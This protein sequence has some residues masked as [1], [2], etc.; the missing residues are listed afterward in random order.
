MFKQDGAHL[1]QVFGAQIIVQ[2][3]AIHLRLAIVSKK[4]KKNIQL[5]GKKNYLSE[6]NEVI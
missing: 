1:D 6:I 3:V 5:K 4:M 2:F